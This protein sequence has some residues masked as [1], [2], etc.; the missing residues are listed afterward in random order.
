M[1][2]KESNVR[3]CVFNAAMALTKIPILSKTITQIYPAASILVTKSCLHQT[4]CL[5]AWNPGGKDPKKFLAFNKVIYPPQGPEE[6]R[7]PAV[8]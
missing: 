6:E 8:S 4:A 3:L 5:N 7:R 2:E 1:T